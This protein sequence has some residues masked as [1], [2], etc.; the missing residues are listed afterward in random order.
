M[1]DN[2]CKGAWK[3]AFISLGVTILY[4]LASLFI[5]RQPRGILH[6]YIGFSTLNINVA[7]GIH[8][9]ATMDKISDFFMMLALLVVA[10]FAIMGLMQLIKRKDIR[11]VEPAILAMGVIY[12]AVAVIYILFDKII[13]VN[14]RPII[15]PG[16]NSPETS[17]PS[18]HA[19]VICT[20]MFTAAIAFRKLFDLGKEL[21]ITAT[22]VF[23]VIGFAG[24]LSRLL[25][26]V[27]WVTDIVAGV[28]IAVT[29]AF[30]YRAMLCSADKISN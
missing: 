12:V 18:S 14:Y 2:T 24:A 27:H 23:Y 11:K 30:F 21:N 4:S 8:Y 20:V 19:M 3:S 5:D 22:I 13:V 16:A 26:A 10:C 25:A 15:M 7:A 1:S 28:M 29:L 6:S 17:F 9:N